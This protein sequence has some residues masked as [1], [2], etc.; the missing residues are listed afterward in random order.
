MQR[1][2]LI[3][4]ILGDAHLE[5][6]KNGFSYRLKIEQSY[7]KQ[8]YIYHLYNIFKDWTLSIPKQNRNNLYFQT[9]FS[10]S[11]TFFG[12]QFYK[13]KIKIIPKLI[14]RWLTPQ[15]VAY[16]YMDDGSI[17]SKQS[18]GVFFNTQGFSFKEVKLLANILNKKYELKTS[19]RKQK[20][21]Y[22]IYISGYSYE[23]LK[24]IIYPYLINSM[25]YKFPTKRRIIKEQ[26]KI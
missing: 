2:V 16:W 20:K 15:A 7:K 24:S 1:E 12:K 22:Q 14:H 19:L 23:K 10:S 3:G 26:V 6:S 21:G 8:E 17:K 4:V 9:K 13:N 11:L 18:K 25:Q 5:Q